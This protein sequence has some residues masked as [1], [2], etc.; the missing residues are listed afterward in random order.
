MGAGSEGAAL[1]ETG[2]MCPPLQR[3]EGLGRRGRRVGGAAV[4]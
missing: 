4:E 1:V 3:G 2:F